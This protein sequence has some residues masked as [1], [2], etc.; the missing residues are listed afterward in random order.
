MG[1]PEAQVTE[2]AANVA[3][4]GPAARR[5]QGLAQLR[6]GRPR[7]FAQGQGLQGP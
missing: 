1:I 2:Q 4:A 6:T 7:F 5:L 3:T